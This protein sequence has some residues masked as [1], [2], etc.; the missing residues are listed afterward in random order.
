MKAVS[1]LPLAL[2]LLAPTLLAAEPNTL[3]PE[4]K[5]QGFELL[6]DGKSLDGW[7]TFREEEPR[8][9]WKVVDGTITLTEGG[10]GDLIT[11]EEFGDFDFRCEWKIVSGGNSG[12][13]W[14]S[15]EE[16]NYPW[17]SGP[18]YQILDSFPSPTH[19]YP[20]E[21]EAKNLAGGLYALKSAKPEWSKPA[22]EWNEARLVIQGTRITLYLNGTVT[23]DVD[24]TTDEFKEMLSKS[25]FNGWEHFNKAKQGHI[26]LQDHGDTVSFRTVR[27]RKL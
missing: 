27:L 2:A 10:G 13:I 21:I 15:T 18:E 11:K 5:E 14:R 12:I 16:H 7:R 8:A 3:T 19:K 25:K 6:F 1:T 4:E 20:H 26:A 24:S 9:Q 23:A 17:V 22:G